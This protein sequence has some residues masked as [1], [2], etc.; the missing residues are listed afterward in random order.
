[1][2]LFNQLTELNLLEFSYFSVSSVSLFQ[3]TNPIVEV[4]YHPSLRGKP[5]HRGGIDTRHG[6]AQPGGSLRCFGISVWA[7]CRLYYV[8][9]GTIVRWAFQYQPFD[10][11]NMRERWATRNEELLILIGI[12]GCV[13][14]FSAR[15][16][17]NMKRMIII[18]LIRPDG[19]T[20]PAQS[21]KPSRNPPKYMS[22]CQLW[23]PQG[24]LAS[25]NGPLWR[26]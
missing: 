6:L 22:F 23:T 7:V 5:S 21:H 20:Y 18:C 2:L 3:H 10:A 13:I 8:P 19:I 25:G 1:M 11:H 14:E 9:R 12:W 15:E 17:E 26:C 16:T 4:E 24:T